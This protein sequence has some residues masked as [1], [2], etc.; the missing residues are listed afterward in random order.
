MQ[1]NKFSDLVVQTVWEK[2]KTVISND[3]NVFRKD[4]CGGWINRS[5]YGNR[6]AKYGWEIDHII[7][8]ARGGNDSLPNLQPLHWKNNEAKGDGNL[9]CAIRS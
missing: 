2:A 7:P 4:I 6:N 3:P 1:I 5:S 9:V 8:V